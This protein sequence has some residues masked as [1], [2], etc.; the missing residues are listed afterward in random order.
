MINTNHH[1]FEQPDFLLAEIPVK[2][3]SLQD[4]RIWVYCNKTFSLIEFILHDDFPELKLVGTQAVFT[5]IDFD[6]YREQWIGVYIQ[7]NCALVGVDQ[8]V[9][10]QEAWD[11]LENYFRWEEQEVDLD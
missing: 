4:D 11:F 5:Y 8:K 7:N 10:L 2:N 1:N 6:E 3:G 9:N